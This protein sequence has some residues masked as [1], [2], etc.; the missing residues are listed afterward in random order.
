MGAFIICLLAMTLVLPLPGNATPVKA[1]GM[2]VWS[3]SSFSTEEAR[4]KLVLFCIDHNIDHL[5]IHVEVSSDGENT[6][7]Q[8]AA[9][10]KDLI[11]LAGHHNITT[12]ALRG[13]PKMF[14]SENHDQTLLELRAIIAFQETLPTDS[15]FKGIKYDVEPYRTKA[16]KEKGSSLETVIL[17]YLTLLNRARS[18]LREKAPG[19]WLT[20][21]MPFWWDKDE[22]VVEFEG[23]RKRLSEHVQDVTDFTVIMSYRRDVRQ[24]LDCVEN[25][26]N[27]ASRINKVI[28]PALE[29]VEL[30]K[31][32]HISFWESTSQ[33]FWDVVPQL[34]EAA[35]KDPAM[36]GVMLHCYR[37]LSKRFNDK[38]SDRA[39]KR[40]GDST[41]TP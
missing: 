6:V 29:T 30:E 11:L 34:Q 26:R 28:F 39:R 5:D 38:P 22:F 18:L 23:G 25:E 19:L 15:L 27:Y 2:W 20:V 35:E 37:S 40:Y 3:K 33:E 12:A 36:G 16:W 31:D 1:L 17:D 32:R 8:D 14:F 4:Q 7:V 24:V 9:A 10:L 21:D 13:S 41:K